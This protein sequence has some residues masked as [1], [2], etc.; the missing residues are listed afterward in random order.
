MKVIHS[1]KIARRIARKHGFSSKEE[2]LEYECPGAYGLKK[3]VEE[4]Y[5][6]EFKGWDDFLG[7]PPP[8]EEAKHFIQ[9]QSITSEED[10][11]TFL[12]S[13]E[14]EDDCLSQR[15]PCMP[16]KYYKT[17]WQGWNDFLGVD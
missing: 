1:F 16:D 2:F 11:K 12:K 10:Y 14:G 17:D 13:R 6:N 3:N 5:A 9:K 7:Y 4:I 15:L 8:W